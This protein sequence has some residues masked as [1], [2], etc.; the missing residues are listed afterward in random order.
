MSRLKLL[1]AATLLLVAV[2]CRDDSVA[3]VY[4]YPE[5]DSTTYRLL[6]NA[7][8][9]WDIGTR[10]SG[11]YTV[12]FEVTETVE[13]EDDDGAVVSVEMR[14]VDVEEQG[15]PSPG[16]QTRSFTLRLGPKGE[17]LEVI[18]VDDIPASILEPDQ[19]VFIGTYRPPLPLDDVRLHDEWEARQDVELTG[20]SQAI[21]TLGTLERLDKDDDGDKAE[22]G[23]SG[24]GPLRWSTRLPQGDA[25]LTGTADTRSEAIF[26]LE[27][28]NLRGASSSTIGDFN[29]RVVPDDEE[30]PI[31]G[32]LHLE[33]ELE[34]ERN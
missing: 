17:V 21:V 28:G 1:A 13:S 27:L 16:A 34:V 22:L 31:T 29:V 4:R 19:L 18:E 7:T 5:G 2:A 8:A 14:P 33:L 25:E 3:F 6:A 10:G 26:D 12:E 23:Y 32:T 24:D 9:Q 11:S 30:V 15:L 20:V